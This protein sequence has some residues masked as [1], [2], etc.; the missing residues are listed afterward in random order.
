MSDRFS[1]SRIL[2]GEK[3]NKLENAKILLFGVGGVGG[4]CLDALY[5]T[6]IR[7]ITI[8]DFDTYDITN[9]NRQIA[10]EYNEGKSKVK[11]LTEL[12][13]GIKGIEV[14]V[15]PEWVNTFDFDEFDL[16]LDAIDDIPS[17]VAIAKKTYKKLISSMGSAKKIDPTRIQVCSIWKTYNDGLAKKVRT[18]LK[19]AKFEKKYEVIFSDELPMCDGLGSYVGVTGSFGLALASRAIARLLEK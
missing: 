14:K 11:S 12:Y 7:D 16:V 4:H 1:R 5:R 15:T 6:G 18:E 10:S 9:Q 8:I 13:Q 17:K 2:F 19:K 3:F